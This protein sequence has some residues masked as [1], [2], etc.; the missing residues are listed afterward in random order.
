MPERYVVRG[1]AIPQ[2][3]VS[4]T[5]L[6]SDTWNSRHGNQQ[7]EASLD[8]RLVRKSADPVHSGSGLLAGA[9]TMIPEYAVSGLVR[10]ASGTRL[11]RIGADDSM[12]TVAELRAGPVGIPAWHAAGAPTSSPGESVEAA[13]PPTTVV[14]Q[15]SAPPVTAPPPVTQPV[16]PAN[17]PT[18]EPDDADEESSVPGGLYAQMGINPEWMAL[19]SQIGRD[20]H[21]AATALAGA[22]WESAVEYV[23]R[24][25]DGSVGQAGFLYAADGRSGPVA[26]PAHD[27]VRRAVRDAVATQ[28]SE[29]WRAAIFTVWRTGGGLTANFVYDDPEAGELHAMFA[30]PDHTRLRERLRPTRS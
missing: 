26:G 1:R 4:P 9:T 11:V 24:W 30:E 16:V 15:Q 20:L 2:R 29:P 6:L 18:R 12:L 19:Q 22:D 3:I 8:R 13:P 25:P 17:P 28:R 7:V 27:Q 23:Q 10:W 5:R 14:E 21:Q